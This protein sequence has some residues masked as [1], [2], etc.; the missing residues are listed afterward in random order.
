MLSKYTT[1]DIS[2]ALLKLSHPHGGFLPDL[3]PFS[4]TSTRILGPAYT[5]KLVPSSDVTSP[6]LGVHFTDTVPEGSVVFVSAPAG[7]INAVWGGLLNTRAK[8]KGAKGVVVD[9][10]VRDL[11]ELRN[12]SLM[13]F[14]RGSSTLSA[15]PFT[16]PS[17]IN[18]PVTLNGSYYPPIVIKPGDV[19]VGDVNGV[20][21]VPVELVDQVVELCEKLVPMDEN[22]KTALLEGMSITEAFKKF[23][24]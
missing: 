7:G 4:H 2:D 8:M 1:C 24:G 16:R 12:E 18:V 13:V 22:V 3:T 9:G 23:R 14:A 19:I 15:K 11:D 10:R 17:E 5:V 6:K 20:V 21:C